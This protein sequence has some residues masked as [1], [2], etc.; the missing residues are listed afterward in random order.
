MRSIEVT[1]HQVGCGKV[2]VG[3]G[4]ATETA[5]VRWD[6]G[7]KLDGLPGACRGM[8][9]IAEIHI[10]SP[11]VVRLFGDWK[12]EHSTDVIMQLFWLPT[13]IASALRCVNRLGGIRDITD[14]RPG[15]TFEAGQRAKAAPDGTWVWPDRAYSAAC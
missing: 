4:F 12:A 8:F 3:G 7:E 14:N 1:L 9:T 6:R 15:S 2:D 13:M 10:D 11:D 5:V